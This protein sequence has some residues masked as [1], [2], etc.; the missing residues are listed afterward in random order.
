MYS[1][2]PLDTS[3]IDLPEELENLVELLAE[4]AHDNWAKKRI[5]EGWTYGVMRDD[6]K[7]EHPDLVPYNDLPESEKEYDR[8]MAVETLKIIIKS[9]LEIKKE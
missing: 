2:K 9:G 5:E 6:I 1:P 4:N 3:K 7:K 8:T